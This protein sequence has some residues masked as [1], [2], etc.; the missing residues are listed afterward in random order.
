MWYEVSG[1]GDCQL[2]CLFQNKQ[3][4]EIQ[5]KEEGRSCFPW[6]A[7]LPFISRLSQ[8]VSKIFTDSVIAVPLGIRKLWNFYF[9]VSNIQITDSYLK[10]TKHVLFCHEKYIRNPTLL[11]SGALTKSKM[12]TQ[13]LP[14]TRAEIYFCSYVFCSLLLFLLHFSSQMEALYNRWKY[15]ASKWDLI[16]ISATGLLFHLWLPCSI[17]LLW[18]NSPFEAGAA[19]LSICLLSCL[20]QLR[21]LWRKLY[22]EFFSRACFN[23]TLYPNVS[24][25]CVVR[26]C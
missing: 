3:W 2:N 11:Y 9:S 13:L 12:A 24:C 20:S 1:H 18:D 4:E 10:I 16:F 21:A 15:C 19:V 23:R 6:P 26:P 14:K 7:L 25:K 8:I 5:Q 22:D 17:H